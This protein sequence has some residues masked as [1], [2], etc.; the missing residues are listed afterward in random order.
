MSDASRRGIVLD[1][2]L[3]EELEFCLLV[4]NRGV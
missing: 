2:A 3:G 1:D 4:I